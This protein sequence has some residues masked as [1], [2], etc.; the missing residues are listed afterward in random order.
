MKQGKISESQKKTE[1]LDCAQLRGGRYPIHWQTTD[2]QASA[3]DGGSISDNRFT[4]YSDRSLEARW[5]GDPT[6]HFVGEFPVLG[7][8]P[9]YENNSRPSVAAL[10]HAVVATANAV[11]RSAWWWWPWALAVGVFGAAGVLLIRQ[12]LNQSPTP[13]LRGY[14]GPRRR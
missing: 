2:P 4:F 14:Q 1:F 10:P 12:R 8:A 5:F 13:P 11:V 6:A 7:G 3:G 9:G